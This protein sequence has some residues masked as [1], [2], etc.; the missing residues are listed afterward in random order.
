MVE[1]CFFIVK[2]LL[3]S[4]LLFSFPEDTILVI[5]ISNIIFMAFDKFLSYG[6]LLKQ[7]HL[8]FC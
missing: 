6:Y 2:S 8:P 5:Y 3:E 1:F 4:V 7:C